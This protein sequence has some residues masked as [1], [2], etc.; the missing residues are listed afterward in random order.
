MASRYGE[1]WNGT[2]LAPGGTTWCH[3]PC[4]LRAAGLGRPGLA[5]GAEEPDLLPPTGTELLMVPA[6]PANPIRLHAMEKPAVR[7][8]TALPFLRDTAGLR[9]GQSIRIAHCRGALEPGGVH[10][11]TGPRPPA[12]EGQGPCADRRT[13]GGG[14]D[15][16]RH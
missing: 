1:A 14:S 15:P 10:L 4:T 3:P 13:R 2:G 9:A 5:A 12:R 6:A 7:R 16:A 11:T 8:R